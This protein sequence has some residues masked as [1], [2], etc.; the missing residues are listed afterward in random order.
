MNKTIA[1]AASLRTEQCA[2]TQLPSSFATLAA[3][4]AFSFLISKFLGMTPGFALDDYVTA[5]AASADGLWRQI[6]SQGRFTFAAAHAL[7]HSAGLQQGD[8]AAPGMILSAVFLGLMSHV[9][10]AP[11]R[12]SSRMLWASAGLFLGAHSYLAEYV[13]FRQAIF[14]MALMAVLGWA[15]LRAYVAYLEGTR[16]P[17]FAAMALAF[18]VLAVGTNQLMLSFLSL[19]VLLRELQTH[20]RDAVVDSDVRTA[21]R[22]VVR[23]A[24]TVGIVLAAYAG[25]VMLSLFALEIDAGDGRTALLSV[26]ALPDRAAEVGA[27]VRRVMFEQEEFASTLAKACLWIAWA[28]LLLVAFV[29]RPARAAMSVG[30]FLIGTILA[31]LPTAVSAIWWPVPRTLIALPLAWTGAL[32]IAASASS[33]RRVQ[34]PASAALVCAAV[35]F[36]AHSNSLLQDQQRLNRWDAGRARQIADLAEE[37]HPDVKKIV[38]IGATW[39]YPVA[40]TMAQGDMNMSALSVGWAIDALFDEATGREMDVRLGSEMVSVCEGRARFPAE[41]SMFKVANEV[42]V[43][44]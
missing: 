44:L 11:W 40:P 15:A 30:F 13:T 34:L 39:S 23:T 25:T 33:G 37:L 7:I 20:G 19:S 31:V 42:V 6:L 43:C 26:G 9:A 28:W 10:L 5:D 16:H 35:L 8:F 17:A 36:A 2:T 14:P 1:N 3:A 4:F 24:L 41:E 32:L 29:K 38:V 12:P 27:L 21:A 18:G 22:A